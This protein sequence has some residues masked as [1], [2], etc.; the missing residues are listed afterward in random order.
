MKKILALLIFFL[1]F[2]GCSN[3]KE[4]E[5]LIADFVQTNRNIKVDLS[6]DL[7]SLQE[8]DSVITNRDSIAI[9]LNDFYSYEF[10]SQIAE[11]KFTNGNL[12]MEECDTI[13]ATWEAKFL[14]LENEI[15]QYKT[16]KQ[17]DSMSQS[18]IEMFTESNVERRKRIELFKR[19]NSSEK[20][21]L[22][23]LFKAVYKVDNPL[24][25]N[26]R[27][28]VTEVIYFNDALDKVL[29]SKPYK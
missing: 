7:I 6:F 24:L 19:W 22:A 2:I 23:R 18:A 29:L 17:N 10:K 8:M 3:H 1:F 13:I 11:G 16:V 27:Q 26:V 12:S 28:E 14:E 9:F 20:I 4:Q 25:G 5:R 21:V 15:E